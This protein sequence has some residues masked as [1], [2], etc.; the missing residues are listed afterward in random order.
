MLLGAAKYLAETRRFSGRVA[1]L[2]QPAEEDGG[3]GEVMVQEGV[4]DRF[5][6]GEVYAIHNAPDVD[7]GHFFTTPG[8]LMAAV[9]TAWV[10]V[11]GKGGHGATPHETI[12]PV[13]AIVGMVQALQTIVTRNALALD[14]L[15]ISVT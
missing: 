11:T 6:I 15:V 8:P 12:E 7:F 2:F 13:V 5:D 4:M 10:T 3:G 9:D 1:L 14:E